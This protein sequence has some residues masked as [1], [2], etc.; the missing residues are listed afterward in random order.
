[1][2]IVS[3]IVFVCLIICCFSSNS[4]FF[5]VNIAIF[6]GFIILSQFRRLVLITVFYLFVG[7]IMC[8]L[9]YFCSFFFSP[10]SSFLF[11]PFVVFLSYSWLFSS[12]FSEIS[13]INS[14]PFSVVS[15]FIVIWVVI[16]IGIL[17]GK[18]RGRIRA[19][20]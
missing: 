11:S 9:G 19:Y 10:V 15:I 6:V 20:I 2:Y 13:W 1:M 3:G 17:L 8:V 14:L 16:R 7:G 18:R 5:L 12:F 4:I